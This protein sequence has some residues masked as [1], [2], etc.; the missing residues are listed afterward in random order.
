MTSSPFDAVRRAVAHQAATA[1]S[2]S[3]TSPGSPAVASTGTFQG[4]LPAIGVWNPKISALVATW[5]SV[6][7]DRLIEA[8]VVECSEICPVSIYYGSISPATRITSYGDGS[9]SDYS[10]PIPRF[11]PQGAALFVVWSTSSST[12]T[13]NANAQLRST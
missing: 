12:K 2:P 6:A 7:Y 3:S 13:G 4:A 8:V 11:L 5:P 9:L 1:G 10:P